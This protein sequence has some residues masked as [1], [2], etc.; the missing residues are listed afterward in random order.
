MPAPRAHP[1]KPSRYTGPKPNL[2]KALHSRMNQ[3]DPATLVS[4]AHLVVVLTSLLASVFNLRWLYKLGLLCLVG[5]HGWSMYGAWKAN[6]R[7]VGLELAQ[8]PALP[9]LLLAILLCWFTRV[10]LLRNCLIFHT[11]SNNPV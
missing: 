7:K 5:V 4:S 1:N 9:Y 10:A 3:V 2:S 8:Q 11:H 6:G